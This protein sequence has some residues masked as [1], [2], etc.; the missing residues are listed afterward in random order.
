M[1]GAAVVTG[2]SRGIGAATALLAAKR[3]YPVCVNYRERR[4][5]AERVVAAIARAGGKAIAVRAD[6]GD[7]AAVRDMFERATRE[8]GPVAALV[9]N[10]GINGGHGAFAEMPSATIASVF[11]TN[12]FGAFWCVREAIARMAKSRGGAGGAIVNVTSQA[13]TFGGNR[14][15]AY[16]ASKAALNAFTIGL[17]REVAPDGIRINAVSPGVVATEMASDMDEAARKRIAES[18]PMG[19]AARP[20]EVAEVVVWL[21]SDAASYVT[22]AIVPVAG[23]R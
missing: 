16:A 10:A 19:R 18:L 15:T 3:G 1:A 13:A 21:L 17:A 23:G 12:I 4:D 6:V 22:G 11:A 9:N 14:I 8:L 5:D 7:E 2:A 20:E